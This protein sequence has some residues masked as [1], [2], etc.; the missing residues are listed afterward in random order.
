MT[1]SQPETPPATRPDRLDGVM[2]LMLGAIALCAYVVTF[3]FGP[4]NLDDP[5]A[6]TENPFVNRLWSDP[7]NL[8]APL[9]YVGPLNL[10]HPV[11]WWSHQVDSAIFGFPA[12]G[13]RHLVNALL[14]GGVGAGLFLFLRRLGIVRAG[15]FLL[16][17]LFLVHPQRVEPVAWLTARKELL[18]A[19]FVL[20]ACHAWITWRS[21]ERRI[22]WVAGF[23]AYGAAL[24]SHPVVVVFPGVLVFLDRCLGREVSWDL[25]GAVRAVRCYGPFLLAAVVVAGVTM[26]IHREGGLSGLEATHGRADRFGRVLL[27]AWHYAASGV[28]PFRPQLFAI[29]PEAVQDRQMMAFGGVAV[30]AGVLV[31]FRHCLLEGRPV[32]LLGV[33][34][35][36]LFF[37]P[38]SGLVAMSPY[39]GADRYTYLPHMGVVM[40]GGAFWPRTV[41][42]RALAAGV[43]VI[44]AAVW[45]VRTEVRLWDWRSSEAL[46]RAEVALSPRSKLAP[47]HLGVAILDAGDPAAA[48]PWFE[49]S[50]AIDPNFDLAK[51]NLAR[52]REKLGA[53]PP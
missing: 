14:H 6:L 4:I 25:A 41:R 12:W 26:A 29:P 45:L 44:L 28:W 31:L 15:A 40:A 9:W 24:C 43:A 16:T 50:L 1:D 21:G 42:G 36:I 13:Q 8:L 38:V 18:A 34:W 48:I 35:M 47:L 37:L 17:L 3:G 22:W 53:P 23:A 20:L 51:V 2:A 39:L 33:V 49:R 19:V 10:W 7:R 27:G 32:A 30:L 52:A 5:V 11:T 46:F